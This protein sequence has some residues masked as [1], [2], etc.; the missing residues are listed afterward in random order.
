MKSAVG[1]CLLWFSAAVLSLFII[2]TPASAEWTPVAGIPAIR[3]FTVW[4]NGDT[5]AAGVDTAVYVSTNAGASW[6]RSAK[7][8]AGV[9]LIDAI[10]IRNGRL[11]AGTFGQG[12]HISDDLGATWQSFNQGLVGGFLDS[13]LDISA[14]QLRG[15]DLFAAM[16]GAGI[17]V[18]SLVGPGEW[19][20]FGD[21]FEPNQASNVNDL[22][23][24]GARL[25]ATA[26]SNGEVFREDPGNADW[27]I[28]NL[29]NLGIHAGLQAQS[30]TWT[31]SGWVVGTAFGVFRSVAGQEPWTLSGLGIGP[32][33]WTAF[34]TQGPHLFAAFDIPNAA[35]MAA[36]DDNGATWHDLE[37]LPEVFVFDMAVVRDNLYAARRDGL[38]FNSIAPTTAVPIGGDPKSLRFAM[39]GPQPFRDQAHL[40]F[41]MPEAGTASIEVLDILG[42]RVADRI[43]G[44]WSAGPHE[45][46]LDA[47]GLGPG[48]YAAR[49]TV[50]GKSEV[51]RLVHI[52]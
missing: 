5:I 3:L 30:V 10:W 20:H 8:V 36:S 4:A 51:V 52:R 11:Y 49:L 18:R 25:L 21:A 14:L 19:V 23:L 6:H 35:V 45:V 40:R 2:A 32:I 33:N 17:Y 41:V 46:S 43:E 12:V 42:R 38:W 16:E 1:L 28:S 37:G 15:S 44:S 7:P 13:Q 22:A 29:D 31:G 34:A 47:R 9:T 50:A 48:V 24:G 27:T 39:A 26:G